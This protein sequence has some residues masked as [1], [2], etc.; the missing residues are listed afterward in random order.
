MVGLFSKGKVSSPIQLCQDQYRDT[1]NEHTSMKPTGCSSKLLGLAFSETTLSFDKKQISPKWSTSQ[2]I[3]LGP[4]K[5]DHHPRGDRLVD[6]SDDR[7]SPRTATN[8]LNSESIKSTN[9]HN[10]NPAMNE[11]LR[12]SQESCNQKLILLAAT[13]QGNCARQWGLKANHQNCLPES[14][15]A[16]PYTWSESEPYQPQLDR[17]IEDTLLAVLH[18]D[19]QAEISE[20]RKAADMN[21]RYYKLKDL[22]GILETR[23][24]LWEEGASGGYPATCLPSH[25]ISRPNHAASI[26]KSGWNGSF[27]A[28]KMI[29]KYP[30][31]SDHIF[32]QLD[33][34]FE[35]IVSSQD[36]GPAPG[37]EQLV[38]P[39]PRPGPPHSLKADFGTFSSNNPEKT[40]CY[41]H[42][43]APCDGIGLDND[44]SASLRE[45]LPAFRAAM[46][47]RPSSTCS[48]NDYPT[49]LPTHST[50]HQLLSQ[51]QPF[52]ENTSRLGHPMRQS[53]PEYDTLP[54]GF[55]RQN[56][57]Y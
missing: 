47:L 21:R 11:K 16:T 28:R 25:S 26:S 18:V 9:V 4:L 29:E 22:Q 36:G 33:V 14:R 46:S 2:R 45:T 31:D 19:L 56:K 8:V 24:E 52:T 12:E 6:C 40:R 5:M 48:K 34:L 10:E 30:V 49:L 55:W 57:L 41:R 20:S 43:I 32:Q 39:P 7:L 3:V 15:S 50:D 53:T 35:E 27:H 51:R 38:M 23:K 42:D 13:P 17:S 44:T 54:L 37:K 1:S